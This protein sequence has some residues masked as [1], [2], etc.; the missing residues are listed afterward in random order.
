MRGGTDSVF[1]A[2]SSHPNVVQPT[3]KEVQFFDIHFDR[4]ENWYRAFFPIGDTYSIDI[5]PSYMSHRDAAIR[6]ASLV[7]DAKVFALLRDPTERAV[8]HH[9]YRKGK[10][11]ELRSFTQAIEDELATGVE[12]FSQYRYSYEIPYLGGGLYARQLEPWLREFGSSLKIIDSSDL[13][14]DSETQMEEL[15]AFAGLGSAKIELPKSNASPGGSEPEDI[16]RVRDFFSEHDQSLSDL[17]GR[18][19]SWM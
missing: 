7:P 18:R 11:V 12:P 5:S 16:N 3:R 4:G 10:G 6:A 1:K 8:S 9:R 2:L 13:F 14:N 19:F 15:L 17:T